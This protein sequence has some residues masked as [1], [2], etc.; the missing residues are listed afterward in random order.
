MPKAIWSGAISFGLVTV[1]VKVT[2]AVRKKDVRFHQ[3]HETDGARIE[4]RRFCSLE[5]DE[6]PYDQIIKG[7]EWGPGEHVVVTRAEL[8]S[9]DPEATRT[10]DIQDFV[11]EAQIDPLYYQHA[12]YLVPDRPPA[13]KPYA[14]LR[15]AMARTGKVAVA[16]FVMRSKEHLAVVRP[17][18]GALV[19][20]TMVFADEVVPVSELDGLP[21]ADAAL[22]PRE[23]DMAEQLVGSLSVDFEPDKY[24]DHYRERLLDLIETKAEGRA[25]VPQPAPAEAATGVVDLVAALEASLEAAER[26]ESA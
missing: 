4:Y 11:D 12:Y 16:R 10:I 5:G 20:S 25:V 23:L 2:T 21:S 13:A 3:L 8:E 14:L 24:R 7:Y 6:V 22:E 1:P 9:L 17:V 26:R 18:E 15:E 19:L